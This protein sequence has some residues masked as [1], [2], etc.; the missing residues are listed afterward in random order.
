MRSAA[1]QPL[2]GHRRH[3]GWRHQRRRAGLPSRS[4][5]CSRGRGGGC[6]VA[7]PLGAGLPHRLAGGHPRGCPLADHDVLRLGAAP[8]AACPTALP[9]RQQPAG[10]A[11]AAHGALRPAAPRDGRG[12]SAR[13][14]RDRLQLLQ[15]RAHHVLRMCAGHRAL[16]PLAAAG[17]PHPAGR[18]APAGLRGHSLR[19]PG[20][21]AARGRSARLVRR[22]LDAAGRPHLARGPPR[23]RADPDRRRR[24]HARAARRS[25]GDRRL[26]QH[27]ADR[28][29]RPVEHL[30]GRPGRGHRTPAAHQQHAGT[31]A[32][33]STGAHAAA[34]HRRPGDRAQP[35]PG[36]H[37]RQASGQPA[38]HDPG[39]A[40]GGGG[41]RP[42]RNSARC[43]AGELP[44]VRV[45][46][47]PRADR[48]R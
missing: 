36:R 2:P 11:A 7:V 21:L 40:A 28:R 8:L 1:H 46:V 34:A 25:P 45:C 4:L 20:H 37:R 3:I 10:G 32:P 5:R 26:P 16:D 47:H 24:P 6:L 17:G 13:P 22:R 35:A 39:L 9:A 31:A 19:V 12:A 18:A 15:R 23:R 41:H 29:P 14:G 33:G 48:P 42:G 27:R 44:A 30:S 43:R 38:A